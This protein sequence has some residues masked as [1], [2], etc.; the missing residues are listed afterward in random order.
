[1]Y[2]SEIYLIKYLVKRIS[3]ENLKGMLSVPIFPSLNLE[4]KK[5]ERLEWNYFLWFSLRSFLKSKFTKRGNTIEFNQIRG[6]FSHLHKEKYE[7]VILSRAFN[8]VPK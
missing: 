3:A 6:D 8:I 4:E 2:F 7:R 5:P 1:M